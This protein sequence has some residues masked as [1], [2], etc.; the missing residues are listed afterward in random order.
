MYWFKWSWLTVAERS[1]GRYSHRV[2]QWGCPGT[3][4][5]WAGGGSAPPRGSGAA[6]C[7]SGTCRTGGRPAWGTA[8]SCGPRT[9]GRL[10]SGTAASSGGCRWCSPWTGSL[11]AA[12][13]RNTLSCNDGDSKSISPYFKF[14]LFYFK[15]II[16]TFINH[17]QLLFLNQ[18]YQ[19]ILN[20][21]W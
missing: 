15:S 10:A 21:T 18:S 17:F 12:I 9:G 20:E 8:T 14:V 4:C 6:S 16:L 3:S 1:I 2:W 11:V 19:Y 5:P 7:L 13:G